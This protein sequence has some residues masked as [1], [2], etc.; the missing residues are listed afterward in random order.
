MTHFLIKIFIPLG[1]FS[2][3]VSRFFR[4]SPWSKMIARLAHPGYRA[5]L[6]HSSSEPRNRDLP[7]KSYKLVTYGPLQIFWVIF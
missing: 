5:K 2:S 7:H 6:R 4:F 3:S 1:S